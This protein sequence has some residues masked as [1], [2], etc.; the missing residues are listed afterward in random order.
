MSLWDPSVSRMQHFEVSGIKRSW[1]ERH[2]IKHFGIETFFPQ[3]ECSWVNGSRNVR[4]FPKATIEW[5][6]G[7]VN[8]AKGKE[9]EKE[10]RRGK[11]VCLFSPD[12]KRKSSSAGAIVDSN[13]EVTSNPRID[14][15]SSQFSRDAPFFFPASFFPLFS[16]FLLYLPG[17]TLIVIKG[18]VV[19]CNLG[20]RGK[21][22]GYTVALST[23]MEFH[24]CCRP[25]RGDLDKA[26]DSLAELGKNEDRPLSDILRRLIRN[27]AFL[28]SMRPGRLVPRLIWW[29]HP[30]LVSLN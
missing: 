12:K 7:L 24:V 22:V 19:F 28:S 9:G 25:A 29:I 13:D 8:R 4:T 17:Y 5:K 11:N 14:R 30:S 23:E 21:E 18:E 27:C 20:L 26:I 1:T 6:N 2:R 3:I 10:K 15:T 16:L